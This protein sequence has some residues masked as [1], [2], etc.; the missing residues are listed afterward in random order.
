[1]KKSAGQVTYVTVKCNCTD[2]KM[3]VMVAVAELGDTPAFKAV[4]GVDCGL[5]VSLFT[6]LH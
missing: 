4:S 1:M 6:Q 3:V 5:A 2:R